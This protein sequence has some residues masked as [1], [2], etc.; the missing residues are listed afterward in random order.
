MNTEQVKRGRQRSGNIAYLFYIYGVWDQN[1]S[2][3]WRTTSTSA[4]RDGV[5]VLDFFSLLRSQVSLLTFPLYTLL[6]MSFD[7]LCKH[8]PLN[9]FNNAVDKYTPIHLL[10]PRN[11]QCAKEMHLHS[12]FLIPS[13]VIHSEFFLKSSWTHLECSLLTGH[14]EISPLLWF[15]HVQNINT[16]CQH[17]SS[18]VRTGDD[19][20]F[21]IWVF[22]III[23]QS[24]PQQKVVKL[25]YRGPIASRSNQH[26][27]PLV[28]IGSPAT[29]RFSEKFR[30]D[31][32]R[33]VGFTGETWGWQVGFLR[34]LSLGKYAVIYFP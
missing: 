3:L 6:P 19:D 24:N 17:K 28:M 31:E 26:K 16:D 11:I 25:F 2:F 4:A 15:P 20:Q 9:C 23:G 13:H 32:K 18:K 8:K 33:V 12:R 5:G 1:V 29:K 30:V 14:V 34:I 10:A 27:W 7:S 22:Q 21:Y